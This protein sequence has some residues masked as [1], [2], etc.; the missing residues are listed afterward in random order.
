MTDSKNRILKYHLLLLCSSILL[1]YMEE[2]MT[3]SQHIS[4]HQC[5]F[6][7]LLENRFKMFPSK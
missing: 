1:V 3:L 4:E 7:I 5:N 6:W 2:N